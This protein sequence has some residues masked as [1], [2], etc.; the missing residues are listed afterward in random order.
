[1]DESFSDLAARQEALVRALV[2]GADLPGGFDKARVGAAARALLRKRFGEVLH[3]WPDLIL[4]RDAYL[5]WA[6][7]RPTR[8]S[9]LDGW[10]FAR[11]H[12]ADLAPDARAALAVREALW[13][14]GADGT[15]A[16]P[17]K[18]P[19]LRGFPG[20]VVVAVFGK[21]K[22]LRTGALAFRPGG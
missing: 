11:A 8:G 10:D 15:A 22:I 9:W 17:R 14:Y 12:R 16:R 18:A 19:A 20:G 21:A 4:H 6:E 1:M 2:A 3:P 7:G 13:H 5:G